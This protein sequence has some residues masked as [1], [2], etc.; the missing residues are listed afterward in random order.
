MNLKLLSRAVI[1][2]EP[3]LTSRLTVRDLLALEA[4]SVVLLDHETDR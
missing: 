3:Q 1:A 2:V 4:G